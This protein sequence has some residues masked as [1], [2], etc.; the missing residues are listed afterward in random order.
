MLKA[1]GLSLLLGDNATPLG[2]C[3]ATTTPRLGDNTNLSN[4]ATPLG[5]DATLGDNATL[6]DNDATLGNN[7]MLGNNAALGNNAVLGNDAT[8]GGIAAERCNETLG[9]MV[10]DCCRQRCGA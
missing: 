8:H 5:N 7:A 10:D 2:A 9:K 1:P 6:S 4:D 3:S